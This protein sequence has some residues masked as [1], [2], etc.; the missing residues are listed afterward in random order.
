MILS[1]Q[2]I[3]CVPGCPG[4][5]QMRYRRAYECSIYSKRRIGSELQK[6]ETLVFWQERRIHLD[7]LIYIRTSQPIQKW[8]LSSFLIVGMVDLIAESRYLRFR[9]QECWGGKP[10]V[11][12]DPSTEIDPSSDK[13]IRIYLNTSVHWYVQTIPVRFREFLGAIMCF[14]MHKFLTP[15]FSFA[16]ELK[17][18]AFQNEPYPRARQSLSLRMTNQVC[19]VPINCYSDTLEL[20]IGSQEII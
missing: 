18:N 13:T 19:K 6:S 16:Q 8:S 9:L 14:P 4:T 2:V 5:P 1:V 15:S 20:R 11:D 17:P 3:C 10:C 12:H 7:W